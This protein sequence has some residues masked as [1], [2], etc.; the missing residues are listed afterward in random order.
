MSE[1]FQR[2][3]IVQLKS[4]GPNMTVVEV[5]VDL[6]LQPEVT[7]HWFAGAKLQRGFFRPEELE[8]ADEADE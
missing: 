3:D 7:C 6:D 4:G 8:S 5:G 2:G 1:E